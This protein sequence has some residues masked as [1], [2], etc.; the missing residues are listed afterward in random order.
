MTALSTIPLPPDSVS[1]RNQIF[2]KYDVR[3][4]VGKD[5]DAGIATIIGQS[6]AVMVKQAL[7]KTDRR[8]HVVLGFDGRLSSPEL[9]D[10]CAAGLR[11]SGV[12]VTQIGLGPTPMLYFAHATIPSDG[13][14]MITGSH[15]P[16]NYNGFKLVLKGKALYGEQIQDLYHIAAAGHFDQKTGDQAGSFTNVDI[17]P[18]YLD[19]L[20]QLM[21]GVDAA[22][23]P[24]VVWDP[25]NGA[26]GDL[27]TT[28]AQ[29]LQARGGGRHLVINGAIDGT[30]PAHHPDPTVEK[31]LVQLQAAVLAEKADLGIAFD[32]DADR[33]GVVDS[34]GRILWG[35]QL[36][37]LYAGDLLPRLPGSPIVFDVKVSQVLIDRITELGGKPVMWPSGH[38]LIKAKMKEL[39]APLAGEMSGHMFFAEDY[40]GFD[41]ALYGALLL[42]KI[43]ANSGV[44][45][46][47]FFDALPQLPSTPELRF[48]CEEAEKFLIVERLQA[49]MIA[50]CAASGVE[51]ITLDG[52]RVTTIHGCWL[53]RV[54]NT[55]NFLV[56]RCEGKDEAGFQEM[57]IDM[58]EN[59]A[60]CGLEVDRSFLLH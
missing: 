3:G 15:N 1:L 20:M 37:A 27:I 4:I 6:F 14:I 45:L 43:I 60:A 56:A 46:T 25:G 12:D 13:A 7:G 29:K 51:C 33:I 10:A 59:L 49:R 5:L 24:N 19:R 9:A 34:Q 41:D 48:P 57:G 44:S 31:N 55:G 54:S 36:L 58:I 26:A 17:I 2:R 38:S 53:V 23:L 28:L 21:D 22:K 35:D 50:S 47:E 52:V 40:Y 11:S 30:F 18:T 42:I 39:K 8:P 32:G 16:A